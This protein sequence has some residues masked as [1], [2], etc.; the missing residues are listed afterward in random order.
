MNRCF[1][2]SM[3]KAG[4]NLLSRF[5]ILCGMKRAGH[6][7]RRN[8][9]SPGKI[10]LW[11]FGY[12]IGIDH[13]HSISKG[14]VDRRFSR[15]R[16]GEFL[17]A[18]VGHS[19]SFLDL[20]ERHGVRPVI[21]VRDPRAVLNSFV[22]YVVTVRAHPMSSFFRGLD[23]DAR[24]RQALRGGWSGKAFLEPM[25]HRCR[26]LTPWLESSE[27]LQVR[28]EDLVGQQGG[29]SNQAQTVVM[30][31]LAGHLAIP[32]DRLDKAAEDLF[33]DSNTFRRGQIA[34]WRNEIPQS[35]S[36]EID[37]ELAPILDLWGYG[38]TVPKAVGG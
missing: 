23:A 38:K 33:G 15:L 29:G 8:R 18:H 10:P 11:S 16:D 30:E 37:S 28:F 32:M 14:A 34:S 19:Y 21:V 35:M 5:L 1:V 12:P 36:A 31:Q 9:F 24:Y 25:V 6:I 3:P 20:V 26:G 2:N 22:H 13:L 4:T 7:N 17:T 27:V